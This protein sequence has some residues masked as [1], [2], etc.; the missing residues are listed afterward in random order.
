M[1]G[2]ILF[3]P[4]LIFS[5]PCTNIMSNANVVARHT[6]FDNTEWCTGHTNLL[7]L[8]VVVVAATIRSVQHS[9]A[10]VD[11]CGRSSVTDSVSDMFQI[12]FRSHVSNFDEMRECHCNYAIVF[13]EAAFDW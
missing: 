12:C 9:M 1:P 11:V 4:R 7:S 6:S 3:T 5:E 10:L 13:G 8:V 2:P